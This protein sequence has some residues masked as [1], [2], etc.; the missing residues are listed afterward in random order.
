MVG[1]DEDT[2]D[3]ESPAAPPGDPEERVLACYFGDGEGAGVVREACE[4][5]GVRMQR[6]GRHE[7]PNPGAHRHGVVL[8][9]VPAG[10]ERRFEWS[11]RLKKHDPSIRVILLVHE[12]TRARVMR[13][14]MSGADVMLGFP[15][16]ADE[17]A[18]KLRELFAGS[19]VAD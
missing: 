4:R 18:A 10:Q 19:P 6:H 17:L 12:P 16:T 2:R 7:V 1:E 14:A 13:G 11:R 3:E 15:V 8:L 9:D 5:I